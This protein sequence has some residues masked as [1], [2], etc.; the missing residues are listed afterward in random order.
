MQGIGQ[1][2]F[3]PKSDFGGRTDKQTKGRTTGLREL[4]IKQLQYIGKSKKKLR[5][6]RFKCQL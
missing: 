1:A 6:H 3:G 5:Q 2:S 4:D